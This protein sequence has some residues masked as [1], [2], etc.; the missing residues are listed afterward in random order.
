V[1]GDPRPPIIVQPTVLTVPRHLRN[2]RAA[3]V[4]LTAEQMKFLL[5]AARPLAP[6]RREGFLG[7]V[8]NALGGQRGDIGDGELHRLVRE[9][10]SRHMEYPERADSE[11]TISRELAPIARILSLVL[12]RSTLVLIRRVVRA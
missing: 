12:A 11:P 6:V 10:Q 5:Q 7:D 1:D 2:A 8:A 9:L 4:R 3:M